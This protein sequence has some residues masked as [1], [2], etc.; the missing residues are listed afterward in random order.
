MK[1]GAVVKP[2]PSRTHITDSS[3]NVAQGE[4]DLKQTDLNELLK[5]IAFEQTP[6]KSWQELLDY[7]NCRHL[8]TNTKVAENLERGEMSDEYIQQQSEQDKSIKQS[9]L[10]LPPLVCGCPNPYF[11]SKKCRSHK[12]N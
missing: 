5:L 1:N 8:V 4:G 12:W 10:R 3:V 6:P 11:H 7:F 2:H 9:A